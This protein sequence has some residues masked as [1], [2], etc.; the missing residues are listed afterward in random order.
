MGC[1]AKGEHFLESHCNNL[2]PHS[3][4]EHCFH[5]VNVGHAC[6][7]ATVAQLELQTASN[8]LQL[9]PLS[10]ALQSQI[11]SQIQLGGAFD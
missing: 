10:A 4:T 8:L 5:Y 6:D 1:L 2:H 11:S 9:V 7:D 3:P